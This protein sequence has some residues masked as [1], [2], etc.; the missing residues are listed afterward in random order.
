MKIP[1]LKQ[2]DP[3][4]IILTDLTFTSRWMDLVEAEKDEGW[5]IHLIGHYL[6]HGEGWLRIC[7]MYVPTA[8]R[9]ADVHVV[10]IQAIIDIRKLHDR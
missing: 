4:E 1:K 5:I 10:P 7:A 3:V 2:Y 6:N 9:V 8:D